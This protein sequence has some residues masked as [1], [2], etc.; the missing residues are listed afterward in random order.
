MSS[1]PAAISGDRPFAVAEDVVTASLV[2]RYEATVGAVETG[3]N[4]PHGLHWCLAN[5][6][7]PT[8]Q[9][10]PDGHPQK[11]GFLPDNPLPRRMWASSDVEFLS[12]IC[13]GD[14]VRRSSKVADIVEKTG[15]SGALVFVNVEHETTA[16]GTLCVR[17]TQTIVYR[18]PADAAAK[19]P[20]DTGFRHDNVHV[21]ETLVPSA[22]TLFRYS[23]L[24][25]NTHRIHYDLDYAMQEEAYP[26]LVVQGPLMASLLLRF[27]SQNLGYGSIKSFSFHGRSP[28]YCG[29]GLHLGLKHGAEEQLLSVHGADGRLVMSAT[30]KASFDQPFRKSGGPSV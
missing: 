22:Q 10:G 3:G 11:G 23:A 2:D 26:A 27:A 30:V 28:A 12:P 4:A 25:F 8:D 16:S 14:H 21:S 6:S 13:V 29:Q 7:T 24:T 20:A 15:S 17:E 9:L 18:E 5:P 1:V 19:L